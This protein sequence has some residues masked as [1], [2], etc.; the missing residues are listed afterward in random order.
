MLQVAAEY[1]RSRLRRRGEL[2]PA[3]YTWSWV[4]LIYAGMALIMVGA[5]LQRP[6]A[7]LPAATVATLV[8]VS[9]LLL[10]LVPG[11][12]LGPALVWVTA[13]VATA[14]LLFAT[15]TP[16][17]SGFAPLILVLMV[18]VVGSLAEVVLG[19]L[20][21]GSAAA[22]LLAASAAHRLN[23]VALYLC[24]VALGW[25]VGYL[26]RTQRQ[27]LIE[28][29]KTQAYS[30]EHAAAEERQRITR[31][32]HDVIAHS[33]SITL[34]HITGARRAL[35]EDRDIDDA[36]DALA[37]AERLGRQAMAD[38]RRTIGLLQAGPAE[39]APQ[40]GIADL[41]RLIDDFAQ[42]GLPVT[43]RTEGR[44]DGVSAAVGLALYRIAEESLANVAKHA[45]KSK[46]TVTL[47]VSRSTAAL[48]VVNEAPVAVRSAPS[49]GRG[50][51]GMRQRVE[52]LGGV[53]DVG[54]TSRGWSVRAEVP[55]IPGGG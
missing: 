43:L 54:P 32:V 3:G 15:R 23:E 31:E 49:N 50:L 5:I 38:I 13:W 6:E 4:V 25:L 41:P 9:P 14:I 42:A 20:A 52:L 2:V 10:F 37:D 47:R 16:V 18:M 24:F 1:L 39:I 30:A 55:L 35:Q 45:A 22:L 48:C 46:A 28:Q 12:K 8:A 27:L 26:M 29:Q 11:V 53:L 7:D 40:P 21:L 34:L 19:V 33:L 44:F 36:V 17:V 51:P